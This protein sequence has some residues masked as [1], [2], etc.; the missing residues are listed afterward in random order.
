[1]SIFTVLYTF[2]IGPLELF[3]DV[4]YSVVYRIIPITPNPGYSIIFLSLAMNFLVL[5]LYRRADA[6]QE[7]QRQLELRLQPWVDHIKKTFKGDERFMILQT[8]Y[9]QNGYKPASVFRGS[10]PLL[11]EVPFFIAAYQFLSKLALLNGAAMGPIRDLGKPDALLTL[12]GASINLLP[13]LM[14]AINIVSG[15]IYTKG[16]PLKS[17]LQLYGMAFVFLVL[18]YDSPA[19]LVFYWTLNNLFSLCKNIYYKWK[20]AD[21]ILRA[22]SSL[23]G[24]AVFALLFFFLPPT[25]NLKRKMLIGFIAI[26]LELPLLTH[27]F[28]SRRPGRAQSGSVK[29]SDRQV[30]FLSCAALTLLTGLLIPTALFKG[31]V[32]DFVNVAEYHSPF[33]YILHAFLLAGGLFMVWFSIFYSLANDKG[34][35]VFG[36]VLLAGTAAALIDYLGYGSLMSAISST[37]ILDERPVYASGQILGNLLV[38]AAASAALYLV[39]YFRKKAAVG[40]LMT[41]CAS[42]FAMSCVNL[43]S[44]QGEARTVKAQ[45]TAIRDAEPA[46]RLSRSG[47]NVIVIMLD[48][49]LAAYTPYIFHERPELQEQFSGFT[50][51]PHT[52]SFGFYTNYGSPG[53]YGGYDYTPMNGV[54]KKGP[55]L[56]ERQNEALKVMPVLFDRQG[57]EVT[58]CDPT[59]AGYKEI[60]DLSV[61]KDYPQFHTFITDGRYS[62]EIGALSAPDH[63]LDRNTFCYSLVRIAPLPIQDILYS[64]GTYNE[65][66]RLLFSTEQ[67]QS[68][69]S[70]SD[71][72]SA[73]FADAYYVLEK[74][75]EITE[76]DASHNTFTMMSNNTTHEPQLLQT[77]DYVPSI[78]VDNVE[79]DNA[80]SPR[81]SDDGLSIQ[82]DSIETMTHYH[83]NMAAMLRLGEWFDFLRANG[84]Y[85]NTRI[86]L[87]AD[88][89]RAVGQFVDLL[90]PDID[91]DIMALNPLLMV[92][93]FDAVGFSGSETI[94][95]NADVPSIAMRGIVPDPVNPFTGRPI[96]MEDKNRTLYI[97]LYDFM[98]PNKNLT[99]YPADKWYALNGDPLNSANW[100][101][102]ESLGD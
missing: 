51:Y 93:D 17:K 34:K 59:Y 25:F 16:F 90:C 99:D 85:D 64:K 35:R 72:I 31:A 27:V 52:V 7:E 14:T 43:V 40:I 63:A 4:L 88:H 96:N 87:V 30:F 45:V 92:K 49:A 78:H 47:K 54:Q 44:I 95:T 65:S 76:C 2:F 39:W 102:A 37:L 23:G 84:V 91:L 15:A 61:F 24:L 75:P 36:Y 66:N 69:L 67:Q 21:K 82:L 83:V 80:H 56:M 33:L 9:R 57:Y 26:V 18:L 79:Y 38:L 3:F 71:G 70:V 60:P 68:Q 100:S 73:N 81:F 55:T 50:Y 13:I 32:A 29:T 12:F 77:P 8:Y 22:A 86:I 89:G 58:I 98:L 101:L 28:R 48:R 20:N 94:M 11:L 97:P 10:L 6:V 46:I 74:L 41:V 1:M 42:I 5:P 62:G 53:I 19:G